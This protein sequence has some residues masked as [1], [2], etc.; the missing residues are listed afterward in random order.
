MIFYGQLIVAQAENLAVDP[1]GSDLVTGRFWINTASSSFK[2]YDGAI[3]R[4]GVDTDSTQTFTNKTIS[5]NIAATLKPSAGNTLTLPDVTDTLV[6]RTTT[7]TLTNKTL[8][9]PVIVSKETMDPTAFT[10]ANN[11][12][13]WADVTGLLLVSNV[14]KGGEITA[15]IERSTDSGYKLELL[16]FSLMFNSNTNTWVLEPGRSYGPDDAMDMS[17]TE[18]FPFQVVTTGSGPYTGQVQYKSSNLAG[19]GYT[20]NMD[21]IVRSIKA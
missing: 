17:A 15:H 21:F 3:V 11:Q 20:G 2:W 8:S 7:D 1:T 12:A 6:G 16:K 19:S 10:V 4:I 18:D 14:D 5:G 13:S 9:S